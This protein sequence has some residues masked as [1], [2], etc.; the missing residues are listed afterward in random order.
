MALLRAAAETYA[1]CQEASE[2][3][4]ATC[5]SE[6][7]AELEELSGSTEIWTQ[8]IASRRSFLR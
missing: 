1:A 7:K 2:E 4:N 8:D 3:V 5:I 6:A